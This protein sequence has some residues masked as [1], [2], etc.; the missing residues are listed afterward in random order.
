M[1]VVK[2]SGF[3]L[4]AKTAKIG[5][6][7]GAL[8]MKKYIRTFGSAAG[9]RTKTSAALLLLGL[10]VACE[11]SAPVPWPEKR[12]QEIL[13][14]IGE[15]GEAYAVI[16]VCMPLFKEDEEAKFALI[17]EIEADRYTALAKFDTVKERDKVFAFYKRRGG[18]EEQ[19]TR[20]EETYYD[21]YEVATEELT[22]LQV[23]HDTI[24]E[25]P[26]TLINMKVTRGF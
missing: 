25:Y 17:R 18:T 21:A 14:Q 3:P 11:E 4:A 26:N 20:I 23:C 16:D 15:V 2:T 5:K 10:A 22:S 1:A 24:A 12:F 7:I 13:T 9:F 6:E 8:T 19:N